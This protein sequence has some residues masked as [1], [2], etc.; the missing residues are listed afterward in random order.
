[1]FYSLAVLLTQG[2]L[3]S[4]VRLVESK[5]AAVALLCRVMMAVDQ[6]LHSGGACLC[7]AIIGIADRCDEDRGEID[8]KL[9][10]CHFTSSRTD[11]PQ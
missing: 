11:L 6:A 2:L 4:E 9:H 5:Q 8:E 3:I 10:S 7:V 1:M